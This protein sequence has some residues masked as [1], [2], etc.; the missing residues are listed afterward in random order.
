[1][2][3]EEIYKNCLA[4]QLTQARKKVFAWYGDFLKPLG[5]TPTYVYVLGVLR[6]Q[7]CA[8]PSD[9]SHRL[10][11]ERPTVT[12]V[13]S[14]MEE[15]GLINR[16]VNPK[17]RRETLVTLT[18][19]GKQVSEQAY[20]LLVAADEALNTVLQGDFAQVKKH[21]EQLNQTLEEAAP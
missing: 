17:N 16:I 20:P 1:M 8:S 12:T 7:E 11:L 18:D 6:D 2:N 15:A 21:V 19:R 3:H 10:E 5:L 13:L 4:F 9:I 14:R